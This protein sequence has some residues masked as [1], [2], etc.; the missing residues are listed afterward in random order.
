MTI[1]QIKNS[2][3]GEWESIAP[4]I[5][6]SAKKRADG[7]L[8]P[9]YLTRNFKY[10]DGDQ[11]ELLVTNFADAYGK[12]PVMKMFLKGHITWHGTHPIAEGA[13]KVTFMADEAYELTPLLPGFTEGLNKLATLGFEKWEIGKSQSI[14]RKT[15]VPFSLAEGQ[16]FKEY[17][18]IYN[19]GEMM[20]W[21]AR[22]VDGRGFDTEENRPTNL[23]IPMIKKH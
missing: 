9:F 13:Q 7:T 17:D 10:V 3:I 16:I 18:L 5:R 22:N 20:F 14:F 23:Q 12:I 2:C 21:G 19:L 11:F 15:F 6:P 4:E 8:D 1:E